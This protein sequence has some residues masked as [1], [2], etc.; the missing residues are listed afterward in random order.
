MRV[1]ESI[2]AT[3]LFKNMKDMRANIDLFIS[4][5]IMKEQISLE[6][7]VPGAG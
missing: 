7:H 1:L 2:L 3:V 6:I 5:Q 4:N